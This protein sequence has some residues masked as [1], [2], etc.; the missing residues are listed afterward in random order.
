[1]QV[2]HSCSLKADY[3]PI[4]KGWLHSD[5]GQGKTCSIKPKNSKVRGSLDKW[6]HRWLGGKCLLFLMKAVHYTPCCSFTHTSWV[7]SHISKT[8]SVSRINQYWIWST[9]L[10]LINICF[11][12]T[13]PIPRKLGGTI[14]V[15]LSK[16]IWEVTFV[17][18]GIKHLIPRAQLCSPLFP[19][20]GDHGSRYRKS[21]E[22]W[23]IICRI[24]D[25]QSHL[26]P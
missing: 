8:F 13:F 11:S 15:I 1:M 26:N 10:I 21:L 12:S 18:S 24:T 5:L 9:L 6:V 3:N 4:C 20:L 19:S 23:V 14:W 25:L 7:V 2:G 22:S 17:T 16:K